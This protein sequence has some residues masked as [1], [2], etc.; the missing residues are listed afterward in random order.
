MVKFIFQSEQA[1]DVAPENAHPEYPRPQMMRKEWKNLNGLWQFSAADEV[2]D[3]PHGKDLS[4]R[5][6]VPF[7]ME[8][9][10]SGV[11]KH[12]DKSWYRRTFDVPKA[13]RDGGK[14]VL[15]HFGAVDYESVVSVNGKE[16]PMRAD[17]VCVHSDTPGAVELAA[18]VHAA[19]R[20]YLD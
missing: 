13:W 15:L 19:L 9:A 1:K 12:H 6:L 11:G 17:S 7:A 5:I 16:I 2:K 3:A 18:A 14:R 20:P 4:G 8:S 10:L